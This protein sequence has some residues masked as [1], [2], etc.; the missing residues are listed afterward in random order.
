MNK[1]Q[2][3]SQ[4]PE[5]QNNSS[6]QRQPDSQTDS[7]NNDHQSSEPQSDNDLNTSLEIKNTSKS[8]NQTFDKNQS[9]TFQNKWSKIE[10]KSLLSFC[11]I[12]KNKWKEISKNLPQRSDN[13]V[14]NQFF[15]L[16]RKGLRKAC[17]SIGLSNNTNKVNTIKPK[18]LI[19]F[20]EK[21]YQFSHQETTET[22]C[23][24]NLIETFA[25]SD[26][27]WILDDRQKWMEI[28]PF[29]LSD[30]NAMK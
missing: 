1:E 21:S 9:K 3:E 19:A 29:L 30:L 28:I 18:V 12:K 16:I 6:D 5:F 11:K 22:V 26:E 24:S 2:P 25:L 20:F 27:Y 23:V 14:K 13:S 7:V 4:L 10:N 8:I 17:K 15:A